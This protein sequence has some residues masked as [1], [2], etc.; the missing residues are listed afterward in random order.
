MAKKWPEGWAEKDC[1]HYVPGWERVEKLAMRLSWLVPVYGGTQIHK[2]LH[3]SQDRL[4]SLEE[5]A[6]IRGDLLIETWSAR[7][8]DLDWEE[9]DWESSFSAADNEWY[10]GDTPGKAVKVFDMR[11]FR[12]FIFDEEHYSGKLPNRRRHLIN[13]KLL[14]R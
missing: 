6:L 13:G 8:R 5:Q 11:E 10:G 3:P 2:C 7:Q 12:G 9:D 1:A 14:K 4:L